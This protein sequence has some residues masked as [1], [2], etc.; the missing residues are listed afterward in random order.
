MDYFRLLDF[1][2]EPFSNS[3][4]PDLFYRSPQHVECL[5]KLE[6]SVRLLRGLNVVI[7][8]VG[9]GK[10]TICRRIIR[11]LADDTDIETYL[12]LDPSF[13]RSIDFLR[14]VAEIL[15]IKGIA[16]DL[17]EWHLKEKIKN[18]LFDKGVR[19]RKNLV[20]IIDEGQK[21]QDFCLEILREFLNYET[22]EHK[23][24]QI[25]IFAQKEF[26]PILEAHRA[27]ADRVNFLYEL[28]PLGF[29]DTRGM[30]QFRLDTTRERGTGKEI[31]FTL[32]ALW[33][34]YR[35]TRG[36]PRKIIGLCHRIILALII[37]NQSKAGAF[38]VRTCARGREIPRR[39]W[40][41]PLVAVLGG[42]LITVVGLDVGYNLLF[43]E[44]STQ[45]IRGV[46][47]Q[48]G[49]AAAVAVPVESERTAVPPSVRLTLQK[50]V[51]AE[52]ARTQPVPARPESLGWL[53]VKKDE[54]ICKVIRGLYG[55]QC[56]GNRIAS[57]WKA[58]PHIHDPNRIEPGTMLK[59][60]ATAVDGPPLLE[61]TCLIALAQRDNLEDAYAVYRSYLT[62]V[63]PIQLFPHWNEGK[64][65]QFDIILKRRF[66]DG[67]EAQNAID[68][69]P[70]PIASEA[71]I[72]HSW[73][74]DTIFFSQV[75]F[76]RKR[77]E[78]VS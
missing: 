49:D 2:R 11:G 76:V 24:L 72:I 43:P 73:K 64:G 51:P 59:L 22:N 40:K 23:L 75:V 70:S 54:T 56:T 12:I 50:S 34:I 61:G 68:R 55:A 71:R 32:P 30:V 65:L 45:P 35:A 33:E 25:I 66:T 8:D 15:G 44:N 31:R 63:A 58:N 77:V 18:H 3:P 46:A 19:E 53:I 26:Y 21:I 29:A 69:L 62:K 13:S 39:S 10:T 6:L 47:L 42:L 36:Y 57:V 78:R 7:G 37:R 17:T 28:H 74:G 41:I 67:N 48:P 16:P 60:P 27:F 20:L 5:Q 14:A 1:G 9:A 4:E 52:E 38:L